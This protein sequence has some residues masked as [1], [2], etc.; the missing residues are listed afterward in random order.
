[1]VS[2]SFW[3]SVCASGNIAVPL[4]V[5]PHVR[6]REHP[7]LLEAAISLGRLQLVKDLVQAKGDA[8]LPKGCFEARHMQRAMQSGSI[9]MV[10]YVFANAATAPPRTC[11]FE[12]AFSS[13]DVIVYLHETHN[14]DLGGNVSDLVA[15]M[16]NVKL[17]QYLLEKGISLEGTGVA[18]NA[19]AMGH[20][21]ALRW[22]LRRGLS[23]SLPRNTIR[24]LFEM[25]IEKMEQVIDVLLKEKKDT[26]IQLVTDKS[27][28]VDRYFT[29]S[30]WKLFISLG[31]SPTS[32]SL[33][34]AINSPS[35]L[36]LETVK[37]LRE[38]KEV[39]FP[40]GMPMLR[41]TIRRDVLRYLQEKGIINS[42]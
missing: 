30:L 36:A 15:K 22:C 10:K 37:F 18:D 29:V 20:A 16:G 27:P 28:I 40:F 24:G 12:E 21:E 11:E 23:L 6:A 39:D 31:A 14:L 42:P 1:M 38:E 41:E 4:W 7:V 34:A 35:S 19:L 2:F 9:E 8:L 25:E 5:L 3:K 33:I 32:F 13:D 26:L 17:L